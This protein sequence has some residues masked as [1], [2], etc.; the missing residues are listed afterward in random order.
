[1]SPTFWRSELDR[2]VRTLAR[3]RVEAGLST[4]ELAELAGCTQS[5]VSATLRQRH[6][7]SAYGLVRLADALGYRVELVP[8]NES[9]LDT[10]EPHE[11]E[12][13]PEAANPTGQLDGVDG[14]G[15]DYVSE[16]SYSAK[17]TRYP[18]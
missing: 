5:T 11:A 16:Y 8:K 18:R 3:T 7:V 17:R 2:L 10:L 12:V 1:M 6:G 4:Y 14:V 15:L 13:A 9:D